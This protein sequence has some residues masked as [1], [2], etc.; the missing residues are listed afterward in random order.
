MT[1]IYSLTDPR[2]GL[3]KYIGKT[4]KVPIERFRQH[5]KAARSPKY[6]V[7]RWIA[8]LQRNGMTPELN[9][10]DT[11]DD[12]EW[13][14]YERGYIA[15]VKSCGAKLK[16]RTL[17]GTSIPSGVEIA[18]DEDK[19]SEKRRIRAALICKNPPECS[20]QKVSLWDNKI[21]HL[22]S[23]IQE[24][25]KKEHLSISEIAWSSFMDIPVS[26]RRFRFVVGEIDHNYPLLSILAK[27]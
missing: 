17:G 1:Y 4:S 24:A 18:R 21:E 6:M 7:S 12:S 23:S 27:C 25:A 5:L 15:L 9:I 19:R 14:R 3:I 2:D 26:M 11:C 16:N 8:F 13:K 22:Y 20:I 10:E